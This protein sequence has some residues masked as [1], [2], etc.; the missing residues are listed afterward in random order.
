MAKAQSNPVDEKAVDATP[1]PVTGELDVTDVSPNHLLLRTMLRQQS[2]EA[3]LVE[4]NGANADF[5]FDLMEKILAAETA[6]EIF[7]AQDSG[8][9][10]G[11]D[12]AGRPFY[13]TAD[14]I[15]ILKSTITEGDGL[16]FYSVLKVV[17]IATGEEFV[18]NCGG[19]TFMT[20]LHGL[21]RINYFN[22][23]DEQ[24]NGASVVILATPSP[25]GAYLSLKPYKM[26]PV[27]R[28]G[29]K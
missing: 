26:A 20:V 28:A 1:E 3:S 17:E 8:M 16:P 27:Q 12:F 19:K 18:V 2:I 22:V 10:S 4:T 24:P 5:V 9:L 11:K 23:T 25:K 29:K 7:A 21:R 6:E 14:N 15:S 13:L